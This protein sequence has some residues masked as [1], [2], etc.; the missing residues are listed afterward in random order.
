MSVSSFQPT[1][2]NLYHVSPTLVLAGLEGNQVSIA[3]LA[4]RASLMGYSLPAPLA[5]P[6]ELTSEALRAALTESTRQSVTR[7]LFNPCYAPV[8]YGLPSIRA[9][10]SERGTPPVELIRP[11]LSVA[12]EVVNEIATGLEAWIGRCGIDGCLPAGN[13]TCVLALRQVEHFRPTDLAAGASMFW[14]LFAPPRATGTTQT[15]PQPT[16][17]K[18]PRIESGNGNSTSRQS[19]DGSDADDNAGWLAGHT[20]SAVAP[21]NNLPVSDVESDGGVVVL[22]DPDLDLTAE[23]GADSTPTATPGYAS[24]FAL[25]HFYPF[26]KVPYNQR[27][28]QTPVGWTDAI[29]EFTAYT[30]NYHPRAQTPGPVMTIAGVQGSGKSTFSRMVVNGL[31]AAFP[32]VAYLDTDLGQ[33]EFAPA[34]TLALYMLERPILGPPFTH[35]ISPYR[36]HCLG[37]NSPRGDYDRYV[38]A[39]TDLL[40]TYTA[41][42]ATRTPLP[43]VINT[44]GWVTDYGYTLLME[45]LGL[46]HPAF[47]VNIHV[48][49][50]KAAERFAARLAED[51]PTLPVAYSVPR[52]L[53]L[54]RSLG[55]ASG[56]ATMDPHGRRSL[57][58]WCYFHSRPTEA[59][60]DPVLRGDFT[61][62]PMRS[63]NEAVRLS[64]D[65]PSPISAMTYHLD[66][67]LTRQQPYALDWTT[68]T[69]YTPFTDLSP[70]QLLYALNGSVVAL[71]ADTVRSKGPRESSLADRPIIAYGAAPV[72]TTTCL[73]LAVVRAVDPT[74]RRL[75]FLTPVL[76]QLLTRVSGLQLLGDGLSVLPITAMT[77]TKYLRHL[78]L[79]NPTTACSGD[80]PV[81]YMSVEPRAGQGSVARKTRRNIL[82]HSIHPSRGDRR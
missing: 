53:T 30:A 56:T 2:T 71:V 6:L 33:S 58:I 10:S 67:P 7:S 46:C 48:P 15:A 5:S 1:A 66:Q 3:V 40:D 75:Y 50:D 20:A 49:G 61:V 47:L 42:A 17:T 38:A 44:Q 70:S 11:K 29:S 34:G 24:A 21:A 72:D 64:R 16:T 9:D 45:L 80:Q 31:L 12:E 39:A 57:S 52:L 69:V 35:L 54:D 79:R 62:S 41:L 65:T 36:A 73:G 18:R 51:L 59:L 14:P 81:P 43:L 76:P 19:D 27:L 82:R 63:T 26:R 25:T 60:V 13:W 68:L 78:L 8:T 4:G 32:R 37:L 23:P 74:A 22:N 77:H 55:G 28:L